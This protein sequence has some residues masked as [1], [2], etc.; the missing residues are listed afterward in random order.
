MAT[1]EHGRKWLTSRRQIL[2][3]TVCVILILGL[4]AGF[5]FGGGW[6]WYKDKD[7]REAIAPFL[8]LAA[9]V[10]VAGVALMRHFAQTDAD[11]QRRIT[12]SFSKAAEQLAHKEI[13]VRLGGI[14]TLEHIA[15]ESPGDHR[16][17]METLTA[18]VRERGR[19]EKR[20]PDMSGQ[21]SE[22]SIRPQ[23]PTDIAA[24]LTVIIRRPKKAQERENRESWRLDLSRADLRG[25][26][27]S[28]AHLERANLAHAHLEDSD[29]RGVHLEGAILN[30]AYLERADLSYAHLEGA[31]LAG[32]HLEGA[33]L[34]YAHLKGAIVS[35]AHF[36]GANLRGVH[37]KSV[38]LEGMHLQEAD[39]T[40][41]HL[42]DTDLDTAIGDAKTRLPA[43][44]PRPAHWP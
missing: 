33:H 34:S 31:Q 10:A 22:L 37:L 13:E 30:R 41:A 40:G 2:A 12:E 35:D 20:G 7:N 27:L 26:T 17:V 11:R 38:E 44:T 1:F 29:L 21:E 23:L 42:D 36:E 19:W 18:F 5:V 15:R 9:G 25:A 32:A 39:L 8:T 16:T 43:R 28:D 3:W 4:L 14:Y 6:A 24:V